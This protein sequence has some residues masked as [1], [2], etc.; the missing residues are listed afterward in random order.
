[1]NK[2]KLYNESTRWCFRR[3]IT[4]G[5]ILH[6]IVILVMVIAGW[7]NLQKELVLIRHELGQLIISKEQLCEHMEQLNERSRR[8]DYRIMKLEEKTRQSQP[9]VKGSVRGNG[10]A[11]WAL[12]VPPSRE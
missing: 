6:L 12:R 1:M 5:T 8:H 9:I 3:E 4:L 7:S 10:L 11:R 2:R